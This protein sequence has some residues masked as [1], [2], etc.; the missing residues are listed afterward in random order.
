VTRDGVAIGSF[1]GSVACDEDGEVVVVS[2][3]PSEGSFKSG[4][5]VAQGTAEAESAGDF[6]I[7]SVSSV[8]QVARSK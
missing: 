8:V 7:R 3:S 6:V 4:H 2:V 1:G 5:A